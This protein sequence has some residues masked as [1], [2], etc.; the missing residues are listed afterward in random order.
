MQP[1]ENQEIAHVACLMGE[2]ARSWFFVGGW[3]IDLFLGAVTREHNYVDIGIYRSAQSLLR[4]WLQDW[5]LSKVSE[6]NSSPW[7]PGEWLD[8]P[9]HEIHASAEFGP[10]RKLEVLF[11]EEAQE[12]W[13]F[14]RNKSVAALKREILLTTNEGIPY[15]SPEIVLL[16]KAKQLRKKDECDFESVC[17]RLSDRQRGWLRNALDICH[18]NHIWLCRL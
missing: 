3:A 16:Y 5:E 8:P 18:P 11:Q 10:I 1:A 12:Q 2:F 14:R 9:I 13:I 7:Q 15:L 6:G 17:G 4:L